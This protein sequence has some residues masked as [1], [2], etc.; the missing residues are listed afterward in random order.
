MGGVLRVAVAKEGEDGGFATQA[1]GRCL[2]FAPIVIVVIVIIIIEDLSSEHVGRWVVGTWAPACEIQHQFAT[3][4]Y[5][6]CVGFSYAVGL[7]VLL[8][9]GGYVRDLAFRDSFDLSKVFDD[10]ATKVHGEV[11]PIIVTPRMP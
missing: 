6:F 4:E 2:A 11:G 3:P 9:E 10:W 1:R 8:V 5:W 7:P